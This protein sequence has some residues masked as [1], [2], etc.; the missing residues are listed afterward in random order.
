MPGDAVIEMELVEQL[1]LIT[2]SPPHHRVA[3]TADSDQTT[4]SLFGRHLNAFIDSI[5]PRPT[6]DD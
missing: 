2:P 3:S 5:D 6:L 4:Q 1:A